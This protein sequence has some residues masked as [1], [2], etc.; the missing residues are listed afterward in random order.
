MCLTSLSH[1]ANSRRT[2]CTRR[3]CVQIHLMHINS[4]GWSTDQHQ[5][6][7]ANNNR[8][9]HVNETLHWSV[10]SEHTLQNIV[11]SGGDGKHTVH[12]YTDTLGAVLRTGQWAIEKKIELLHCKLRIRFIL[13][14]PH[15]QTHIWYFKSWCCVNYVIKIRHH[16]SL[17]PCDT[18]TKCAALIILHIA[19]LIGLVRSRPLI[20]PLFVF[21]CFYLARFFERST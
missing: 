14:L 10:D 9:W 6:T 5:V 3:V 18:W 11:K 21:I 2:C 13:Y 20:L 7:S 19:T 8:F 1:I 17:I 12:R 15:T 16:F 4:F